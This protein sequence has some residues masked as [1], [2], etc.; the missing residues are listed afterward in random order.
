MSP[1]WSGKLNKAA[2]EKRAVR[3]GQLRAWKPDAT[4]ASGTFLVLG[5]QE[6]ADADPTVVIL[7]NGVKMNDFYT[8]YVDAFSEVLEEVPLRGSDVIYTTQGET[9]TRSRQR[10]L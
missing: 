2:I 9:L 1:D 10:P 3:T 7:Q 8:S 6:W 5:F 4:A